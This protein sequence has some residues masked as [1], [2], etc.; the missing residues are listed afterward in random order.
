VQQDLPVNKELLVRKVFKDLREQL[1]QQ[2]LEVQ[3]VQPDL[4]VFKDLPVL[5]VVELPFKELYLIK[6]NFR[7]MAYKVT[8]I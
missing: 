3:P 7:K 2:V 5:Q 6:L 8:H 1:D 4:K